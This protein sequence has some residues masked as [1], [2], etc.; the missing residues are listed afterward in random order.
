MDDAMLFIAIEMAQ[1]LTEFA[2][3]GEESGSDMRD[4]RALLA[5]WESAFRQYRNEPPETGDCMFIKFQAS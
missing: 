2:D 1:A 3:A 4:I 5:D